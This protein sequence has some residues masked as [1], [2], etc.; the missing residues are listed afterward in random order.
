MAT[1]GHYLFDAAP[2][3][4]HWYDLEIIELVDAT[5]F[6]VDFLLSDGTNLRIAGNGDF[7]YDAGADRWHSHL[8]GAPNHQCT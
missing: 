8:R 3:G 5:N 6:F 2:S 7:T 1:Y 4:I